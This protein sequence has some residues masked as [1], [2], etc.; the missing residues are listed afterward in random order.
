LFHMMEVREFLLPG[1]LGLGIE[2][3]QTRTGSAFLS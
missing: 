2:K 3:K 1:R